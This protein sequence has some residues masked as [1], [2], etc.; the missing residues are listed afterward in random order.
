MEKLLS[1]DFYDSMAAL[2]GHEGESMKDSCEIAAAGL[3]ALLVK[4]VYRCIGCVPGGE[5]AGGNENVEFSYKVDAA[6]SQAFNNLVITKQVLKRDNV[7]LKSIW[8]IASSICEAYPTFESAKTPRNFDTLHNAIQKFQAY[9]PVPDDATA[10]SLHTAFASVFTPA[11]DA[12]KQYVDALISGS[13]RQLT[14]EILKFENTAGGLR[15]GHSWKKDL[16]SDSSLSDVKAAAQ[17]LVK[18]P[19]RDINNCKEQLGQHLA[20]FQEELKRFGRD[21]PAPLV[22]RCQ[23][24]IDLSQVTALEANLYRQLK[25]AEKPDRIPEAITSTRSYFAKYPVDPA[26]VQLVLVQAA[27]KLLKQQQ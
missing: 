9:T 14:E 16:K 25:K 11:I 10:L 27:N 20:D 21:E 22:E 5:D 4:Q 6:C 13:E 23:D 24:V 3:Q 12:H 15:D 2:L 17:L 1:Q 8:D 26:L 7:S 18:T 19:C